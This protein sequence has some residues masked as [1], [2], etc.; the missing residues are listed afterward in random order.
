MPSPNLVLLRLG[1]VL[2]IAPLPTGELFWPW[3]L[4]ALT[5]RAI[6]ALELVTLARFAMDKYPDGQAVLDW[7]DP[8]LW[9]YI[10]FLI[11]VVAVG[12]KGWITARQGAEYTL[13]L[14]LL[15]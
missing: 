11:S 7:S 8:I 13:F 10:L 2:F 12:L 9:A 15:E 14:K 5:G 4:S 6:G 1:I 3:K